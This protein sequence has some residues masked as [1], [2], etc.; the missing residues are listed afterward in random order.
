MFRFLSK[1]KKQSIHFLHIEKTGGSAIKS[2]LNDFLETPK[3][4][5]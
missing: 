4:F 1:N 5:S 2:V 3:Y